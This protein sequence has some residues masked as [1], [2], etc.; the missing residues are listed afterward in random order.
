[1]TV[2]R[3][4][5]GE[6]VCHLMMVVVFNLVAALLLWHA[7]LAQAPTARLAAGIR[8]VLACWVLTLAINSIKR[9]WPNVKH[10]GCYFLPTMLVFWVLV[11]R[12]RRL[13]AEAGAAQVRDI[14]SSWPDTT[15]GV[16]AEIGRAH[17]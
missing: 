16:V 6:F 13:D 1:M 2:D 15:I 5:V 10:A 9:F 4:S 17:V 3:K 7:Y 12:R 14:V 8:I 11:E